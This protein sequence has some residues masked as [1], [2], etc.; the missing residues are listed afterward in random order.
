MVNLSDKWQN[1]AKQFLFDYIFARSWIF[2]DRCDKK[3][4]SCENRYGIGNEGGSVQFDSEIL[5]DL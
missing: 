1:F 2:G 5:L 3:E 4:V